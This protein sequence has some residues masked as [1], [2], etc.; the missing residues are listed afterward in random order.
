MLRRIFPPREEM[1]RMYPAPA[2]SLR[3][4]FFYPIRFIDL[5]HRFGHLGVKLIRGDEQ[6]TLRAKRQNEV[7]ALREW[8]ITRKH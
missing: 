3:I 8:M 2:D 4:F 6:T 7:N 5:I 1:A